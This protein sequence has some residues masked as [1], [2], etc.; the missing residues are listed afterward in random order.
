VESGNPIH[1]LS[2]CLISET[3]DARS[4][5]PQAGQHKTLLLE[6]LL[7]RHNSITRVAWRVRLPPDFRSCLGH[8]DRNSTLLSIVCG[9]WLRS[10]ALHRRG[11]LAMRYHYANADSAA[12][13][14][15]D[16]G[17]PSPAEQM[18]CRCAAEEKP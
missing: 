8:K 6:T 18:R 1:R 14:Q 15:P 5:V 3:Y 16:N 17:G 7:F 12:S 4:C 9:R 13:G 10:L 2:G 11:P